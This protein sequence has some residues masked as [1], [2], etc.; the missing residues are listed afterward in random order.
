MG[1]VAN[2]VKKNFK[3]KLDIRH[4]DA[5]QK[6][7]RKAHLSF[8]WAKMSKKKIVILLSGIGYQ[9]GSFQN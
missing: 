7:I 4:T 1:E 3:K 2:N 5:G 6:A 9:C 8:R